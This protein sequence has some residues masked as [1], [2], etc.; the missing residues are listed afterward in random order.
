MTRPAARASVMLLP[1]AAVAAGLLLLESAWTAILLYHLGAGALV[2]RERAPVLDALRRGWP[3]PAT[4]LLAAGFALAGIAVW[5]LWPEARAGTVPLRDTLREYG[6]HGARWTA[7]AVY[8]AVVHPLLEAAL[9]R[10]VLRDGRSGL[11]LTDLVFAGYHAPVLALFLKPA[12]VLVSVAALAGSS[13]FWRRSVERTG[14]LG[15]A[16]ATHAAADAGIIAAS[17]MLAARGS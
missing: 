9:W 2:W 1:Y 12:W 16:A 4:A 5:L 15:V 17:A 10:I 13:W 3:L 8:F 14:G 7:F 6:L 11:V